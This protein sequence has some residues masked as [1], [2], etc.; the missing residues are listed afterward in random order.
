MDLENQS[1]KRMQEDLYQKHGMKKKESKTETM[2]TY[3]FVL[4]GKYLI[5]AN[6]CKTIFINDLSC[7]LIICTVFRKYC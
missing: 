5:R 1:E 3:F 4:C 6:I 2:Y 7:P